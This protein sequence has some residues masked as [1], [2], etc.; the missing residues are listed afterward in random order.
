MRKVR[1][2]FFSFPIT[3]EL[4]VSFGL[5]TL[6]LKPADGVLKPLPMKVA[7]IDFKIRG[8][9]TS[10]NSLAADGSIEFPFQFN[11]E[12]QNSNDRGLCS[13]TH[14]NFNVTYTN[15]IIIIDKNELL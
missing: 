2:Y 8:T 10:D 7:E 5:T 13:S 4:G 12:N 11:W 9:Q 3:H 15:R 6:N 1:F 14:H